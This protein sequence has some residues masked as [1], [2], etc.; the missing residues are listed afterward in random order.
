MIIG[1]KYNIKVS[2][3]DMAISKGPEKIYT[4]GLGSCVA[5]VLYDTHIKIA[6]MAHIMLPD[7]N[8]FE[9]RDNPAKFADTALDKLLKDLISSGAEKAHIVAKMAGGAQM[10][11]ES[12]G[13]RLFQ[14]GIRNVGAVKDK[15][16]DLAIPLIA[17]DTGGSQGRTVEFDPSTGKMLVH[18]IG[19][20]I[21]LI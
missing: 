8:L 14:I 7:S 9:S 10:F 15:L 4:L 11:K 2:M 5:V 6:G 17:E 20:D 12:G 3:A 13:S 16:K 21:K 19:R 18:S 1:S